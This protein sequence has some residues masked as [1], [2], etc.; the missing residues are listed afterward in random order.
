M[1]E[2]LLIVEDSRSFA[3]LLQK[4]VA[5]SLRLDVVLARTMAE[6][7]ARIKQAETPFFLA[8]LDL[9]LPDAANGEIVDYV[10]SQNIPV[11]VLTSEDSPHLRNRMLTKGI[12]DYFIKDNLSVIDSVIYF[13]DR[14]RR[15]RQI[16]VLVVDDSRSFRSFLVQFLTRYGF[17]VLQAEG[18]RE[19]L[20]LLAQHSIRL[21]LTDYQMPEMDGFQL[22]KKIR[23]LYSRHTL[24]IIGLSSQGNTEL[25]AQFIKAGAND[26]LAKPFQ[27]EELFCRVSQ[28][29]EI[30][31]KQYELENLVQE[32]TQKLEETMDQLKIRE[33]NLQSIL[34]TALD[35]IISMDQ[36]G[37][38][39][40]FN[41]AAEQLFG[42][43]KESVIGRTVAECII[44]PGLREK[45]TFALQHLTD[46]RQNHQKITRRLEVQGMRADGNSVDLEIAL[47]SMLSHGRLVYTGFMHDITARKQLVKSLEETLSVAEAANRSKSEFLANMSHEIRTPLNAIL[48]MT[49][50]VLQTAL[51]DEQREYLDIVQ[52]SSQSLL[53][54]VNAI[55]D[56]T[57]METGQIVLA[58]VSFDVGVLVENIGK[59]M[60]QH[61][62]K[63]GLDLFCHIPSEVPE[64][65]LGDPQRLNQV[66]VNLVNNAIKFTAQGEVHIG[67]EGVVSHPTQLEIR[68]AVSDTGIGI[69]PER[70]HTIF[71]RFTQGDGSATRQFGGTGLG[72]TLCKH[73]VE[74]MGGVFTVESEQNKGS[75]F[76]FH[77]LFHPV[78]SDKPQWVRGEK[79]LSFLQQTR[80]KPTAIEQDPS[81]KS[82]EE[83]QAAFLVEV[84]THLAALKQFLM[85]KNSELA[86][87]ELDWLKKAGANVGAMGFKVKATRLRGKVEM[88]Q[89][90]GVEEGFQRLT[91]DFQ[92]MILRFKVR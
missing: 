50:L 69:P 38:V 82:L 80:S 3:A 45:H 79:N 86:G 44:P 2:S 71:D 75:I 61:A 68:F 42:Y 23:A 16:E 4:R 41:P 30:I 85:D 83:H 58:S 76:R 72:L 55:L 18:G 25:A 78:Q 10:V 52:H 14:I 11:V 9:N 60:A 92:A 49:D 64:T 88:K 34:E 36:D 33:N 84:P 77:A 12:L 27:N 21:V 70:V 15:N 20:A 43:A 31:E 1:A 5:E 39:T 46:N 63:K 73:L 87:Q 90:L 13:V 57:K 7:V 65:V 22:I 6:A 28:N 56:L 37:V 35:A 17:L 26:F 47:T 81:Q 67:I 62:H 89:W 29:I 8:I 24:A 66:L 54:L 59:T 32:R 48:G 19:A 51:Q 53:E 91:E 40:H 74:K